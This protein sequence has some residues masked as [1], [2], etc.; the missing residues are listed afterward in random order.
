M[1]KHRLLRL[2]LSRQI[3]GLPFLYFQNIKFFRDSFQK[4][5]FI[6][7]LPSFLTLTREVF[8]K[9]KQKKQADGSIMPMASLFFFWPSFSFSRRE[10]EKVAGM[11][12]RSNAHAWNNPFLFVS[13]K[14]KALTEKKSAMRVWRRFFFLQI[15][16][17]RLQPACSFTGA[18]VRIPFPAF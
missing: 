16:R 7:L 1:G 8:F 2:C 15:K 5:L 12:E 3:P 17:K 14:R 11:A 6:A 9:S 18:W 10:K 13:T 4:I